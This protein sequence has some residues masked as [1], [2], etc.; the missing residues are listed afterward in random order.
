MDNVVISGTGYFVPSD[1]ISNDELAASFNEYVEQHNLDHSIDIN[2]GYLEKFLTSNPDFILKASGIKTRRVINKEGILNPN[3]MHPL[4]PERHPH[5]LSLQCEMA[6]Y[7]A[8]EALD[9]ANKPDREI[10]AVIVACSNLQRPYP[11]IAI[12][13]QAA[14]NTKGFA[15]DLNAACSSA[16]FGL[17]M[18]RSLILSNTAKCVLVVNPEMYTAHLNFRDR[19]SHFIFG[20]GSSAAVVERD[21]T[22]TASHPYKIISG[23]LQ[24]QFSNNIRNNFGFLTRCEPNKTFTPDKLFTQHGK[25]VREEVVPL[26]SSHI[27]AHITDETIPQEKIKRLW[28]HQ[29]NIHMNQTIAHNVLGRPPSA[30]EI[31]MILSEYGNT[32]ASGVLI[33]FNKYHEDLNQGDLGILCSFGAGYTIGSLILEKL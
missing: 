27:C 14:L 6:L 32:G 10:D 29:A 28:L 20:D 19:K 22:C 11:A 12:E 16:P 24:T 5:E 18:A 30:D 26:A 23:K 1:V 4:V 13:L 25:N 33:T 9:R 3:V 17:T 2:E 8:R 31:P 21:D 7:A 15:F